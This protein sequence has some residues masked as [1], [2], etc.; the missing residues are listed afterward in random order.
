MELTSILDLTLALPVFGVIVQTVVKA[1][2][3]GISGA[4]IQDTTII[5]VAATATAD[6]TAT[7]NH[8]LAGT[9][10]EP[11]LTALL[12]NY[13]LS[14]W[15]VTT[16]N[17]TQAILTKLSTAASANNAAQVRVIIKRPHSYGR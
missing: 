12:Q 1:A 13:Y 7:I 2:T 3:G 16:L 5:D 17:S 8:G 10:Q 6:K 9:P 11:Y 14:R 4:V 15:A